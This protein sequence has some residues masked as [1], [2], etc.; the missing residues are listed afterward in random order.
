MREVTFE[1]TRKIQ[2]DILNYFDEWCKQHG[3]H[4]SLAGGTLLGA[5]RHKGFIPWD[6]DID[7]F[8][9][10]RYYDI[11]LKEFGDSCGQ[12][13]LIRNGKKGWFDGY[14]RITD[15]NTILEWKNVFGDKHGI[16]VSVLPVDNFP[17]KSE[18]PKF[19]K[20]L[21]F[22]RTLG[23]IK[24]VQWLSG[25]NPFRNILRISLKLLLWPLSHRY[26]GRLVN[27]AL[28]TYN[29]YPTSSKANISTWFISNKPQKWPQVFD[30]KCFEGYTTVEFEGKQYESMVGWENYLVSTYGEWQKLPPVEERVGLHNYT[31]YWIN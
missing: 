15:N 12:Y 1:E 10:R 5:I 19:L 16:W 2:L 21:K 29:D 30:A 23:R 27:N 26:V 9:E 6:D 20:R 8:M 3:L 31:A 17:E 25:V 4:Y 14:S 18:W 22:S 7:L 28:T 11:F 24:N 13:S